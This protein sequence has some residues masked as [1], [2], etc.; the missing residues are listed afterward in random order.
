MEADVPGLFELEDG[1]VF[2]TLILTGPGRKLCT[3]DAELRKAC[4]KFVFGKEERR[5]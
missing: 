3:R 2:V 1:M 5:Q 4:L